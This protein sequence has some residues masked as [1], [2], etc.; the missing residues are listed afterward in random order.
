[1][2]TAPLP[3]VYHPRPRFNPHPTP[4][5]GDVQC[6]VPVPTRRL[7][8]GGL[9]IL[10]F[11]LLIPS[12]LLRSAPSF[13]L[14]GRALAECTHDPVSAARRCRPDDIMLYFWDQLHYSKCPRC[15]SGGGRSQ[16]PAAAQPS[17]VKGLRVETPHILSNTPTVHFLPNHSSALC[18]NR[19]NQALRRLHAGLLP[20]ICTFH[21]Q[22]CVK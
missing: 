4:P 12:L 9:N 11:T 22:P 20:Y 19:R 10:N 5:A 16:L 21:C 15:D 7:M 14:F 13:L 17:A 8:E 18:P 1:M 3:A 2:E 6:R